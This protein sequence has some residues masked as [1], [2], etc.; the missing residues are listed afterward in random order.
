M[1]RLG[2]AALVTLLSINAFS[3]FRFNT[4]GNQSQSNSSN[5]GPSSFFDKV[6][7]AGGGNFG[8][9]TTGSGFGS[10]GNT[11][12]SVGGIRYTYFSLFPTVGYRVTNQFLLGLNYSFSKYNFP[13]IGQSYTQ[14]GYAPFVRYY[15]QQFFV[16][17]EYDMIK[18]PVFNSTGGLDDSKYYHRLMVGLGYTMPIGKRGAINAMGLYDLTYQPNNGPFLSPFVY[19]VF[20]SF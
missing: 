5:S 18:T 13:D 8:A 17:G 6:Y 19:R 16:Q 9:G 12:T 4:R 2:F 15:I 3:Q 10:S 14:V 1:K 11:G 20:F 7:F